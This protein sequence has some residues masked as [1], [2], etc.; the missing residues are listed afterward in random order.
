MSDVQAAQ[1][2]MQAAA[3][4]ARLAGR[5]ALESFGSNLDVEAKLDG[6]PVTAADRGAEQLAR[7]WIEQRFPD[8]GILGEEFGLVR[9]DAARRWILDPIDG[10]QSFIRGVPLWGTL[11]AVAERDEVLA[12]AAFFPVVDE[13]AA[14][15]RACGCWWN[16]R[17]CAVS[18]VSELARATVLATDTRF[19]ERRARR[20]AWDSLAR[21]AAVARTWG[22]CY[23][24]LLVATG[25]AEAM[26]DDV[27][28]AWDA[29]AIVPIIE[30]A[31]GV[32]TDWTGNAT[33]FGGDV[34]ATNGSLASIVRDV[35]V[36]DVERA[37][38]PIP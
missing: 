31:G 15:G 34:I 9:P 25:R 11:V 20:D 23:G 8:D 3:E 19:P 36:H 32:L 2:L 4:V 10:T 13:I 21:E 6:S 12:G 16:G 30:E 27:V 1:S 35:L 24:Y 7:E 14:A 28:S 18:T 33:P 38:R 22:D 26:V 17:A 29:A 5:F 37:E